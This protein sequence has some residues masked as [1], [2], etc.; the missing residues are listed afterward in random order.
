MESLAPGS[1]LYFCLLLAGQNP[2]HLN[3]K[4]SLDTALLVESM[5]DRQLAAMLKLIAERFFPTAV[6]ESRNSS[7]QRSEKLAV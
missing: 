2:E 4:G 3:L 7:F 1:K 6:S 5:N